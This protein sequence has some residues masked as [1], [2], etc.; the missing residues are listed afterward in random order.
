MKKNPR[1]LLTALICAAIVSAAGTTAL[2]EDFQERGSAFID[3]KGPNALMFDGHDF[4]RF[5]EQYMEVTS[6][7]RFYNENGEP[8]S[9][10]GFKIPCQ[11]TILYKNRT[12]SP[13]P[14]AISVTVEYY[15]DDRPVDTQWNLPVMKPEKVH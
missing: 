12:S 8:I 4:K 11:A 14:E 1:M 7:T 10:A 3:R 5:A 2:A 13:A 9:F 6:Q 15:R